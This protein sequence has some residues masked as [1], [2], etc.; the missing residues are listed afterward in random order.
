MKQGKKRNSINFTKASLL[1]LEVP[2][3]GM[4]TVKKG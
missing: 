3:K 4:A 1:A 2:T